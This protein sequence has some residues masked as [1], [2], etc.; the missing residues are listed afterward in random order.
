MAFESKIRT[1]Q[2]IDNVSRMVDQTKFPEEYVYVDIKTG[3]DMYDAIKTMM[4]IRRL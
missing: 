1:I 4:P 2:W 3:D